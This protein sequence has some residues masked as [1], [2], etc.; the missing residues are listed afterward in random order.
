MTTDILLPL[1][2]VF[3]A[4]AVAT[5]SVAWLVSAN[6]SPARR[7]LRALTDA[8]PASLEPTLFDLAPTPDETLKKVAALLPRSPKEMGRLQRRLT[9]A[10]F[11]SPWAPVAYALAELALPCAAGLVPVWLLG[12]QLGWVYALIAAAIGYLIP[13][14]WLGQQTAKR[15]KQIRNGLADALDMMLVCV[16]AGSG[17]DQAFAKVSQEIEVA[18]PAL[19]DELRQVVTEIRAGRQR[20]E[21]LRNLADRT[22]VDDVRTLVSMLVQTDRFGT[23]I[24]PALRTHADVSRTKRRQRAE[25]RAQKLGVK[26]VFPL[27]FCLF[28]AM[29]VVVLGPVVLKIVNVF[30]GQFAR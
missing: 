7:R 13:G 25:E 5:G 14:L 3:V 21:A 26:L 15:K 1:G 6:L 17:L 9:V 20:A 11:K 18:Y 30:Y 29:Y 16:E 27:V 4:V 2:V 19:A 12:W 23:S 10:G 8:G 28:P 22:K 24:G